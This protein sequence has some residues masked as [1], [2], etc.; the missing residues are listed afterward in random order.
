MK[1]YTFSLSQQSCRR[2]REKYQGETKNIQIIDLNIKEKKECKLAQLKKW[3]T[4]W[5][6]ECQSGRVGSSAQPTKWR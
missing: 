2:R 6:V 1:K 4:V 3:A 5:S